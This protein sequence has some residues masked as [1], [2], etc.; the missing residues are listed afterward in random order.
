M[1]P[2]RPSGG[3]YGLMRHLE[4]FG[5]SSLDGE[6]VPGNQPMLYESQALGTRRWGQGATETGIIPLP[7]SYAGPRQRFARPAI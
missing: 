4:K 6:V 5:R 1:S 2:L 3:G 7:A